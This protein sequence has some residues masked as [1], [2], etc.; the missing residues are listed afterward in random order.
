METLQSADRSLFVLI[1]EHLTAPF[2]DWMLPRLSDLHHSPLFWILIVLPLTVWLMAKSRR[3]VQIILLFAATLFFTNVLS[4]QVAKAIFNRPRPCRPITLADG[5]VSRVVADEHYLQ[6]VTDPLSSSFPSSHSADWASVAAFILVVSRHR[7]RWLWLLLFPLLVGW[8]RVYVGVHYPGDVLGGWVLGS[9]FGGG[10]A[11]AF[12][13][14]Q[15]K[16]LEDAPE[17][18][19]PANKLKA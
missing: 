2:L 11:W 10:V 13:K 14:S 9:L 1:N 8:S 7:K 5:T 15:H 3:N 18:I 19:P 17:I 4:S 16:K 12:T 6:T